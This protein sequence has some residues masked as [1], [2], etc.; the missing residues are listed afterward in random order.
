[1]RSNNPP[2]RVGRSCFS[3][4]VIGD[5]PKCLCLTQAPSD[6]VSDEEADSDAA[7]QES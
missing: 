5:D 4:G 7:I 1:M 6:G 2:R 3:W